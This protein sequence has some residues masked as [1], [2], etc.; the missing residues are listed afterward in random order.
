MDSESFANKISGYSRFIGYQ[1][2]ADEPAYADFLKQ[3]DVKVPEEIIPADASLSPFETAETF[4]ET[5]KDASVALFVPGQKFDMRG[6]RHGRGHGWYDR[7]LSKVP[8]EWLRIGVLDEGML[9]KETLERKSWDEPMDALL[10]SDKGVWR[11]VS[12]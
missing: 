9:S 7:F 8:R 6:T 11:V 12:L 1:P 2:M 10:V 5:L 4:S 3:F